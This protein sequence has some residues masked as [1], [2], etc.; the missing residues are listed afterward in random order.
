M[1]GEIVTLVNVHFPQEIALRRINIEIL[2]AFFLSF[3]PSTIGT[4]LF[5]RIYVCF[6]G[7]ENQTL[8]FVLLLPEVTNVQ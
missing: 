3:S 6:K 2:T 5:S 8:F 4:F 7:F 1:I